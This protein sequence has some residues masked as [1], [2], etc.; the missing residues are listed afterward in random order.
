MSHKKDAS[1]R[2]IWVDVS[3]LSLMCA[4]VIHFLEGMHIKGKHSTRQNFDILASFYC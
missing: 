2:L 4:L 1:T 3:V